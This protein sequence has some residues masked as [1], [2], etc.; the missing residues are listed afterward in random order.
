MAASDV[1]SYIAK[2]QPFAQPIL[3]EIRARVLGTLPDAEQALKWGMPC[4]LF[5]GKILC[6]MASFKAHATFGFWHGDLVTGDVE[7]RM[8]AMGGLG[9][10]KDVDDLPDA[11]IF[12][13]WLKKARK[14]IEDGVKA[15]HVECRGKHP[16]K[17]IAIDP[18]FQAALD[19]H[20]KA[21]AGFLAFTPSQQREYAEWIA[22]AKRPETRDKR[23]EQSINWLS[24]GKKR[25]WKYEG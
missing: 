18:L 11:V 19:A 3:T 24:E 12:A 4:F 10:I 13:V 23:I 15:P 2:A 6:N 17:E 22:D 20:A 7:G 14:L 1:D 25:N 5:K 21:N 16:K 9:K 8:Q